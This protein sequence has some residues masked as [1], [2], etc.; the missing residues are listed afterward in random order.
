MNALD[1]VEYLS[2][3]SQGSLDEMPFKEHKHFAG[4]NQGNKLG[5][6]KL[7]HM[8]TIWKLEPAERKK[9]FADPGNTWWVEVGGATPNPDGTTGPGR[10][11][12]KLP[13]QNE[14]VFWYPSDPHYF[15]ELAHSFC[16]RDV[17]DLTAAEGTAALTFARLKI[18]YV[19]LCLTQRHKDALSEYLEYKHFSA[20]FVTEPVLAAMFPQVPSVSSPTPKKMPLLKAKIPASSSSSSAAVAGAGSSQG[21]KTAKELMQLFQDKLQNLKTKSEAA[22]E[23]AD[24]DE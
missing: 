14:P 18:P 5:D 16:L 4:S 15:E 21:N 9:L 17:Y 22:D 20:S 11:A 24:S 12:K 2:I 8:D 3:V 1:Q 10:G 7:P 6:L 19:G 23:Q 13:V